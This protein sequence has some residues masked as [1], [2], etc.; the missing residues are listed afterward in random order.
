MPSPFFNDN[1]DGHFDLHPREIPTSS[2]ERMSLGVFSLITLVTN[3]VA[4][5]VCVGSRLAKVALET[6]A[7]GN[8]T[9]S[10]SG[11]YS[12]TGTWLYGILDATSTGRPCNWTFPVVEA[13][14]TIPPSNVRMVRDLAY[15]SNTVFG[16]IVRE[17]H[18][19]VLRF[20]NPIQRTVIVQLG[21]FTSQAETDEE[22][23]YVSFDPEL[24]YTS[25]T[26]VVRTIVDGIVESENA[27]SFTGER[28]CVIHDCWFCN[29]LNWDCMPVL[30]KAAGVIAIIALGLICVWFIIQIWAVVACCG[31]GSWWCLSTT[32]VALANFANRKGRGMR[33][34]VQKEA[35]GSV[36]LDVERGGK[37]PAESSPLLDAERAARNSMLII[38]CLSL[39]TTVLACDSSLTVSSTSLSCLTGPSGK[40]CTYEVDSILSFHGP[41]TRSCFVLEDAGVP[42]GQ[43]TVDYSGNRVKCELINGYYTSS[44]E[45]YTNSVFRCN[46]AG[47]CPSA[48]PS[49]EVN[50]T[51]ELPAAPGLGQ[52]TC[53]TGQGGLIQ[54]CLLPLPGCTFS[55]WRI[56]PQGPS[57]H[58]QRIG[59]CTRQPSFTYTVTGSDGEIS[60]SGTVTLDTEFGED[61]E[62]SFEILSIQPPDIP[63]SFPTHHFGSA[64]F[65]SL[66]FA[67][68]RGSPTRNSV[69]DIQ[70][71]SINDL[72]N[73][74]FIYDPEIVSS[75]VEKNKFDVFSFHQAGFAKGLTWKKLPG[76][77]GTMV[78]EDQSHDGWGSTYIQAFDSRVQPVLV[79]MKT[80]SNITL[81][82][83]VNLVCPEVSLV[84]FTGCRDCSE[85]ALAKFVARSTCLEGSVMVTGPEVVSSLAYLTLK[86]EE[87]EIVIRTD[88]ENFDEEVCFGDVCVRVEGHL[89]LAVTLGQ[90]SITYSGEKA[91]KSVMGHKSWR[92]WEWIIF[93]VTAPVV[94]FGLL[95]VALWFAVPAIV[96]VLKLIKIG[97][98]MKMEL[99][100]SDS[101]RKKPQ[102]TGPK[103]RY[104]M[105]SSEDQEFTR[106]TSALSRA[107]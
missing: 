6:Q 82:K 105:R 71:D 83:K 35:E 42:M 60:A 78:W 31:S 32:S 44:F 100:T 26:I 20:E 38:C 89:D 40:T 30:A 67:S 106:K 103:K 72:N 107:R 23:M 92:T 101:V 84:S 93:G 34:W 14:P 47:T 2:A 15:S 57:A 39:F 25:G 51:T 59:P 5:F 104:Q 21:S 94:V 97:K 1:V 11:N 12:Y 81:T 66:G 52:Q 45:P 75:V 8:D 53:R 37:P 65:S 4:E 90:E 27:F 56:I 62:F 99:P 86:E 19:I 96:G 61:Q 7:V 95:F 63:E 33:M 76:V 98:A 55:E 16:Y 9:F 43:I 73:N 64:G 74:T 17:T 102:K 80:K 3:A 10:V 50:G 48:C 91:K 85:G 54:G 70:A 87:Y 13:A 77:F 36:V 79:G 46:G 69:G 88:D 22:V 49:V 18:S 41:G 58:V 29:A 24:F 68:D 28:P